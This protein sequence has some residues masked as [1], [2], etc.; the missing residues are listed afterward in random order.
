M[1]FMTQGVA[2]FLCGMGK[3][4]GWH[5]YLG[6]LVVSL[7][8]LRNNY[9]GLVSV[10]LGEDVALNDTIELAI[11]TLIKRVP[12]AYE[13]N[14]SAYVT[15][16]SLWRHSPFEQTVLIDADTVVCGGI[17]ELFQ[18]PIT[19]THFC[20][21]LTNVSIVKGRIRTWK[22]TGIMPARCDYLMT[23]PCKAINTGVVGWNR[24]KAES[25][26]CE[27][28][29]VT[30][31]GHLRNWTD[32]LAMQLLW[33]DFESQGG[34]MLDDRFNCSGHFRSGHFGAPPPD[35]RIWHFHGRKMIPG[36]GYEEGPELYKPHLRAA[37]EAN[38]GGIRDWLKETDPALW[39]LAQ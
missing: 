30:R 32:E 37:L 17:D 25:M 35:V 5:K 24:M 7:H 12:L 3:R 27:W 21:W 18:A 2:Y 22:D 33:L 6:P 23:N 29:H 19:T 1:V 13:F 20:E 28:E 38:A 8:A 39:D 26:L 31:L 34:V 36:K 4:K 15:K 14:H 9:D 16:A 11:G 10:L